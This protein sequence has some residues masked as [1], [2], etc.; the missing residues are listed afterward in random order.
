MRILHIITGLDLGGAEKLL[1]NTC[2]QQIADGNSVYIIYFKTN[3]LLADEFIRLGVGVKKICIS[4]LKAVV[5]LLKLIRIIKHGDYDVVHCHLPHAALLGRTAALLAGHKNIVNTIHGTDRWYISR[6]L[7]DKI[8]KYFDIKL[9]N[10]PEVKIIAISNAVRDF[11]KDNGKKLKVDKINV[12]Y[13]AINFK[14]IDEKLNDGML[15]KDINLEEKDFVICNIGRLGVEKGHIYLLKALPELIYEKGLKNIKCLIIGDGI[16]RRELETYIQDNGLD[17]NVFLLGVQINP[18][19]YLKISDLFV[20]PSLFEG[21]GIAVL[22][23][24]YCKVPVIASNIEGLA[25]AVKHGITGVSI[26]PGDHYAIKQEILNF[27]YENYDRKGLVNNANE[28]VKEFEISE[29]VEKLNKVYTG[30][31]Q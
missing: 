3:G 29:Y 8:V 23:A 9:N 1:L 16:L 17:N 18:Y 2:Q 26:N 30:M 25:D 10:R 5:C 12:I 14:E 24:Y 21:F 31:F 15:R 11:L 4:G 7:P 13:N 22:E 27:Y 19:K 28:F 20:M 6:M